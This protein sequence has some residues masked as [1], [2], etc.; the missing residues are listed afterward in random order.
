MN[1]AHHDVDLITPLKSSSKLKPESLK[2]AEIALFKQK[3]LEAIF[4]YSDEGQPLYS[5]PKVA[6]ALERKG[7][8]L[9][10]DDKDNGDVIAIVKTLEKLEK[11]C[12]TAEF[13]SLCL[14]L[15]LSNFE[16]NPDYAT[17]SVCKGRLKSI[18]SVCEAIGPAFSYYAKKEHPSNDRHTDE[19]TSVSKLAAYVSRGLAA[20]NQTIEEVDRTRDI[21]HQP[22][23][24]TADIEIEKYVED[25]AIP[26]IMNDEEITVNE[27]PSVRSIF[28][29]DTHRT[30]DS[31]SKSVFL[32]E[33]PEPLPPPINLADRDGPPIPMSDF[34]SDDVGF[35]RSSV[36]PPPPT[37]VVTTRRSGS[38]RY[39]NNKSGSPTRLPG[40]GYMRMDVKP[41]EPAGVV[42]NAY[43]EGEKKQAVAWTLELDDGTTNLRPKPKLPSDR[44]DTNPPGR[45]WKDTKPM[46]T[47]AA[48][49]SD[50]L[51]S[52]GDI[53]HRRMKVDKYEEEDVKREQQRIDAKR[54]STVRI[55]TEPTTRPTKSANRESKIPGA[56]TLAQIKQE[57]RKKV[58]AINNAE[59][60]VNKINNERSQRPSSARSTNSRSLTTNKQQ[61]LEAVPPPLPA[62]FED[63]PVN[64]VPNV[65]NSN[66]DVSLQ[67]SVKSGS[68][69]IR[70]SAE[71][72]SIINNNMAIKGNIELVAEPSSDHSIRIST[73]LDELRN[74]LEDPSSLDLPLIE[75]APV[76]T[77][78][79]EM[80][81]PVRAI[82]RIT[83]ANTRNNDREMI[84]VFG[85]NQKSLKMGKFSEINKEFLLLQEWE[86]S[87]NGSVY[88]LDVL[89]KLGKSETCLIATGSN[90]KSIR[91]F[92]ADTGE[93]SAPIKG[94][95]G[96]IRSMKFCKINPTKSS[97]LLASVGSGDCRPRVWELSSG[98]GCKVLDSHPNTVHAC[99]W[100][101]REILATG[102]ENGIVIIHD[103]LTI[104]EHA[105][106][107]KSLQTPSSQP[108]F[109]LGYIRIDDEIGLLVVGCGKG[110]MHII[111]VKQKGSRTVELKVVCSRVAHEDDIRNI[112]ID[113]AAH[114]NGGLYRLITTSF[115]QTSNL[116]DLEYNSADSTVR[117]SVISTLSGHSDKVLCGDIF[118][119]SG[120]NEDIAA[121]SSGADGKILYWSLVRQNIIA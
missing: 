33:T 41:H 35:G 8:V 81:C 121:L 52:K 15:T 10:E 98:D 58:I 62:E 83:L 100:I 25:I 9:S 95:N 70:S 20:R 55:V 27:L 60:V 28:S 13:N 11:L 68:V 49:A 34:T 101:S 66:D 69:T 59:H 120:D 88:C 80:E 63:V 104:D 91:I 115:D 89:G 67:P 76:P 16:D 116:W 118:S 78:L 64:L 24:D 61:H 47:S 29:A 72:D 106:T 114:Q 109:S 4:K 32:T 65:V 31:G 44:S 30:H 22:S 12:D 2:Q 17:W 84:V 86:N 102:C 19:E 40:G 97:Q 3:Y 87:H 113:A 43:K 51:G 23:N 74:N 79:V 77:S 36:P 50:R 45:T 39:S 96:T 90:D 46:T 107:V 18:S 42:T 38:G 7:K 73:D 112:H 26:I 5:I 48:M 75:R 110:Y 54:G 71:I 105:S 6:S 37:T 82:K 14:C 94:H 99:A 1:T 21:N 53:N 56:K 93:V 103:L 119:W 92:R 57:G 111:L 117:C 85:T 108:V